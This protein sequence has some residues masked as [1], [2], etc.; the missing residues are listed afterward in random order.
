MGQASEK[1]KQLEKE[2]AGALFCPIPKHGM[3]RIT[4]CGCVQLFLEDPRSS[5]GALA[6]TVFVSFAILVQVCE[7][8]HNPRR[9]S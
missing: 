9:G 4:S 3:L 2:T 5:F 7:P 6:F 1:I 8:H